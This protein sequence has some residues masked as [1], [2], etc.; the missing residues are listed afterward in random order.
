MDLEDFIPS[1]YM[2]PFDHE[3]K[4]SFGFFDAMIEHD[5][6]GDRNTVAKDRSLGESSVPLTAEW[7][8][9]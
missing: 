9:Q 6:G 3:T 2:D 4:V 8:A 7:I 1:Y 5:P